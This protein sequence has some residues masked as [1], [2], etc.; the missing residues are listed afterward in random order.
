[1]H[2]VDGFV[3]FQTY[4]GNNSG[5]LCRLKCFCYL[6]FLGLLRLVRFV[7]PTK[8]EDKM[9]PALAVRNV[10]NPFQIPAPALSTTLSRDFSSKRFI[11]E[12]LLPGM[13][14]PIA[15]PAM[16]FNMEL[17]STGNMMWLRR[18]CRAL[19]E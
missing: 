9:I 5:L 11:M 13:L 14:C 19:V 3:D 16:I 8:M 15:P 17:F 18:R 2:F 7:W 6:L 4:K 1:V 10:I 12:M